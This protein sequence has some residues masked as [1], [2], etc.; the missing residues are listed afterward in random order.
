MYAELVLL[1]WHRFIGDQ[2]SRPCLIQCQKIQLPM[3]LR[4]E[5]LY[6][7]LPTNI[8]VQTVS[9]RQDDWAPLPAA[10]AV[11]CLPLA[12]THVLKLI[13]PNTVMSQ[14]TTTDDVIFRVG[15]LCAKAL[16]MAGFS[17]ALKL[18]NLDD[19]ITPS[20]VGSNG[21]QRTTVDCSAVINK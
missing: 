3:K 18:T 21:I 13:W 10:R 6:S 16:E 11:N 1:Y 14:Y 19:F 17:G 5:W 8:E 15:V 4:Q 2:Q 20:Q 12:V 9:R 7:L